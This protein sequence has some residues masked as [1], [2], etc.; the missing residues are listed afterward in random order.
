MVTARSC[1]LCQRR[2]LVRRHRLR[3]CRTQ[4]GWGPA[5]SNS[6]G[7]WLRRRWL[8]LCRRGPAA[9]RHVPNRRTL[10]PSARAIYGS[11]QGYPNWSD[12]DLSDAI[13][14]RDTRQ[15]LLQQVRPQPLRFWKE[16]VPVF[17]GWPDAPCGYLRFSLNSAYEGPATEA[18]RR[19]WSYA[20]LA[21]DHFHMLVDPIAVTDALLELSQ[22]RL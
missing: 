20:Q 17:D 1:R 22:G 18:Q 10:W 3:P 12:A 8:H 2:R 13:P 21:G 16:T 6:G 14:D 19:G 15:R 4:R 7:G 11:G 5:S 9:G